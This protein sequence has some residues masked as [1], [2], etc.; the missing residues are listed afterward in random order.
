M[1]MEV[2][3]EVVELETA[4]DFG[5][6]LLHLELAWRYPSHLGPSGAILEPS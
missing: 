6:I 4:A 3:F 2:W 5:A 1:D